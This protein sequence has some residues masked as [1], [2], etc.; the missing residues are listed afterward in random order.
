MQYETQR[1]SYCITFR[2]QN[3][4]QAAWYR[5]KQSSGDYMV[6]LETVARRCSVKKM[7]WENFQNSQETNCARVSFLIKLQVE[8]CNLIK[9]EAL[10]PVFS[11]EFF[12]TSKNNFCYR[13]LP[14]AAS[15]PF[16]SVLRLGKQLRKFLRR[17]IF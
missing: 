5:Q 14:V 11:C 9:K 16:L 6:P 17:D 2:R 10:A 3:F 7:L 13:T 8:D 12:E 15:L 4:Y 1:L